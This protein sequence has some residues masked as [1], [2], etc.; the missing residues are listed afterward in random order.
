M[1]A[2]AIVGL[3]LQETALPPDHYCQ[4]HRPRKNETRAHECHCDYVCQQ[5]GDGTYDTVEG[6]T[7]KV[8]C[9]H[10]QCTCWPEAPCPKPPA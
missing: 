2:L 8:Y 4:N 1:L 3:A 6:Q 7:C 5:Q 10:E 9:H